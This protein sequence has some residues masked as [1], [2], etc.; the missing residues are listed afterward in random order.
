[1][2]II[3]MSKKVMAFCLFGVMGLSSMA[4][5]VEEIVPNVGDLRI[6]AESGDA[7]AQFQLGKC[8]YEGLGVEQNI[9]E[10]LSWYN[11]SATLGYAP[12]QNAIGMA[13]ETGDFGA[14]DA[15]TAK[16]FYTMAANQG[17]AEAMYNLGRL[18]VDG[19]FNFTA[20]AVKWFAKAAGQ[21]YA[22]AMFDLGHC[23]ENGY[24]VKPNRTTALEWYI[25]ASEAGYD[26]AKEA[27]T[28]LGEGYGND[29]Y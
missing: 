18:C 5:D 26:E 15:K 10:G 6:A 12:A 14:E 11:R 25:K 20:E 9:H 17:Y 22:P 16:K 28:R 19:Y 29:S 24:G 23:Y 27:A 13:Y 3:S 2:N 21:G 8:Y 1:M 7:D 4:Q